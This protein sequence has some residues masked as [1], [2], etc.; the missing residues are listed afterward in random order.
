M[1]R[2]LAGFNYQTVGDDVVITHHGRRTTTL[3]GAMARATLN[4]PGSRGRRR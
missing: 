1:P 2:P 3:R 4:R